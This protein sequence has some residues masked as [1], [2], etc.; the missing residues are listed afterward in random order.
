MEQLLLKMDD[1]SD[2]KI[3]AAS[4]YNFRIELVKKVGKDDIPGLVD[5]SHCMADRFGNQALLTR[6]NIPKYFVDPK[7]PHGIH[8][9]NIKFIQQTAQ[10]GVPALVEEIL[11]EE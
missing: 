2:V 6:T 3:I 11:N 10:N 1:K 9:N 5:I 7:T 4:A 8:L